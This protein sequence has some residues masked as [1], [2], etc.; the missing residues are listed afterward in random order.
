METIKDFYKFVYNSSI[1]ED[2]ELYTKIGKMCIY[3]FWLVRLLLVYLVSPLMIPAYLVKKYINEDVVIV[4]VYK[5]VE[6]VNEI[7]SNF[8]K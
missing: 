6:S 5:Y 2:W 4:S 1:K 3:P 7:I 8:K